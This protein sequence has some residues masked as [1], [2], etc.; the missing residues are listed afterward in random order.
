MGATSKLHSLV[1]RCMRLGSIA[2]PSVPRGVVAEYRE[3][4]KKYF[5]CINLNLRCSGKFLKKPEML[6]QKYS[7]N[8]NEFI[9]EKWQKICCCTKSVQIINCAIT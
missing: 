1:V 9:V 2:F 6:C 7:T 3:S 8:D 4:A 5:S